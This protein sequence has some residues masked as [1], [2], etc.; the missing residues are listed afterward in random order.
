M[1]GFVFTATTRIW[2]LCAIN[3]VTLALIALGLGLFGLA[4]ALVACLWAARRSGEETAG[5]L[6][7]GMWRQYRSEFVA[8]NALFLPQAAAVTL[9]LL[10]GPALGAPA[11][12]VAFALSVLL[13]AHMLAG[14]LVQSRIAGSLGDHW[15]NARLAFML[16]PYRLIAVLM[17]MPVFALIVWW[18]PLPGLYFGLS[19]PAWLACRIVLPALECAEPPAGRPANQH[20]EI[21]S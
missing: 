10:F 18:Q 15:A 14:L 8:A 1:S 12:A 17:L 2:H 20:G 19:V 6:A 9:L 7:A 5:T 21:T 11:M 16:A 3:L 4:P 13:V